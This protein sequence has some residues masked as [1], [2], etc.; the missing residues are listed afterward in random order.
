MEKS[1]QQ[2]IADL[3]E[4]LAGKKQVKDLFPE[5]IWLFVLHDNEYMC[6]GPERVGEHFTREQYEHF[7]ES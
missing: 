2:K 7:K 1:R 4:L 6:M 5:R 3:E